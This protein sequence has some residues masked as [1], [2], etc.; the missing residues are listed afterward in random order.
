MLCFAKKKESPIKKG[1]MLFT[2]KGQVRIKK[3]IDKFTM[4]PN[5]YIPMSVR[6]VLH[7]CNTDVILSHLY[8]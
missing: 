5:I 7:L 6:V 2:S 3:I 8:Y 4:L 1:A